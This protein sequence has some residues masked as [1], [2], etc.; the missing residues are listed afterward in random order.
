MPE[1]GQKKNPV[2]TIIFFVVLVPMIASLLYFANEKNSRSEG[3]AQECQEGCST[4]GYPGH[5]FK[6][7]IFSGQQ[8]KCLGEPAV[9]AATSVFE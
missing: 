1:Q 7:S 9:N 6:W 2:R 3:K 8:C 5:E 4:Q